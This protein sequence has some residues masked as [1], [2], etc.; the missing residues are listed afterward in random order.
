[1]KE[2]VKKI[3]K[4]LILLIGFYI[5]VSGFALQA[6]ERLSFFNWDGYI[7]PGVVKD[8][9]TKFGVKVHII[10][11]ESEQDLDEKLSQSSTDGYDV[12]VLGG[13]KIAPYVRRGW[14]EPID[15]S[16]VPNMKNVQKNCIARYDKAESH[17]VPYTWGTTGFM[18]RKDLVKEQLTS[19]EQVFNPSDDLKGKIMLLDDADNVLGAAL[20]ALGYSAFKTNKKNLA[21][22]EKLLMDLKPYIKRF[23]YTVVAEKAEI[24]NGEVV[25]AQSWNGDAF[26]FSGYNPNVVYVLPKEGGEIWVDNLVVMASS[27]KKKLAMEFINFIHE[28][29]NAARITESVF[30]ATCNQPAKKLLPADLKNNPAIY[31]PEEIVARSETEAPYKPRIKKTI[32]SIYAKVHF[33]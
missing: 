28:P 13:N 11:Y 33:D 14:L 26:R 20:Q 25:V 27:K 3:G 8:F 19:W 2:K 31:P 22:A 18:Y 21:E 4:V 23:G 10:E 12:G 24:L 30:Y 6:Q 32:N 16:M 1:M 29:K 9:E 7:D 5:G 15:F 17:S